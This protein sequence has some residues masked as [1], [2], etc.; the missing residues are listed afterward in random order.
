MS[1]KRYKEKIEKLRSS[2]RLKLLEV[3]RI[4]ELCLQKDGIGSV[5]DVGTGSGVFAEAFLNRGLRVAG[6]DINPDMIAAVREFVP[7]AEFKEAAAE[8]LP[9][10]DRSFDLVFLGHVLHETDDPVQAIKEAARVATM[11][12]AVL[13]WPYKEEELG[14]PLD[15]RIPDERMQ[16]I[17]ISA[18]VPNYKKHSLSHMLLWILDLE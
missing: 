9:Y 17:F 8:S 16:E 6:I 15:H 7:N 18:G 12:V 5:L 14:P 4:V 11:R 3:D 10:P 13:E 1:D 2:E